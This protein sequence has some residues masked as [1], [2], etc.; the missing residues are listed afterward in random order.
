MMMKPIKTFFL[1]AI[2]LLSTHS[3]A[4]GFYAHK[5]INRMAVFTLPVDLFGFYKANIDYITDNAVN[6]DKR[7]YAVKEEAVR[8]Y[9]D[10]DHFEH[11]FPIDTVPKFWKDAVLMYSED[12]LQTYGIVPW[13]IQ[14]MKFRL[15]E[16]F[17]AKDI[18]KI[19]S[20][21][22]DIGHYIADLHVPLHSTENYDGQLTGQSG[23][24]ALWESRLPELYSGQYDF[25]VGRAA[26][27]PDL[28]YA[29]WEAFGQSFA[30]KD[31]VFYLEK[32]ISQ[33]MQE[34]DKYQFETR[35]ST[36]MKQYSERFCLVYHDKLNGM[37]ER[38]MRQSIHLVGS[39]WYTA[40]ADAG[41]PDLNQL[42]LIA[43]NDE[44]RKN[45]ILVELEFLKGKILGRDEAK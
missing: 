44:E 45:M 35:G 36:Q 20:L 37:V 11:A 41:Q 8:H 2:S 43:P 22:A 40:W 26:L 25:F 4:W 33:Q 3:F 28:N 16:A 39:V 14:I 10:A 19:L 6:A 21:S 5:Q 34:E 7:R 18:D 13:Y 17:K 12:T 9:F 29:I 15:T 1:I 24:H 31:S 27:L 32:N 30:A 23:I 42:P 38:R